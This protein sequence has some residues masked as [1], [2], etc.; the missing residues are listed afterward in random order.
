LKAAD[1]P[2]LGEV[3]ACPKGQSI[4]SLEL[5][6]QQTR[7]LAEMYRASG[8]G[9]EYMAELMKLESINAEFPLA[10]LEQEILSFP[11]TRDATCLAAV[12]SKLS[13]YKFQ[14]QARTDNKW[15]VWVSGVRTR[16]GLSDAELINLVRR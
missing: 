4:A 14:F 11:L 8:L 5:R 3:Y 13:G 15:D 2:I 12:Y 9:N 6:Y 10:Y 7:R 1:T 16:E